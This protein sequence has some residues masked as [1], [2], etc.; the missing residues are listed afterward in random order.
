M[1]YPEL[2]S[3]GGVFRFRRRRRFVDDRRVKHPSLLTEAQPFRRVLCCDDNISAGL[4]ASEFALD[5]ARGTRRVM[6]L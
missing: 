6:R 5:I 4:M 1:P 2:R 3:F